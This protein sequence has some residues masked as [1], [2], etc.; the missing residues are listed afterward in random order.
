MLLETALAINLICSGGGQHR[1]PQ[2]ATIVRN[3]DY[4]NPTTV[5]T[6]ASSPYE[7]EVTVEI[8]GDQGR[9]RVPDGIKPKLRSGGDGGWWKIKDLRVSDDEI[10]F[11]V[12]LNLINQPSVRISRRTGN[13]S[14]RGRSGDYNG[15]CEPFDPANV[16]R[17]F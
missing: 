1:T 9:M 15:Y 14:I 10:R 4:S 7:A 2:G 3:H 17:R 8:Q 6:M 13:I 12:T 16:T 11:K 5:S